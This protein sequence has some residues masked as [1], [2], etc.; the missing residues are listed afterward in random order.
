MLL[1]EVYSILSRSFW[2][3]GAGIAQVPRL[4]LC[5][6]CPGDSHYCSVMPPKCLSHLIN[7]QLD[8]TTRVS[9]VLRAQVV[10]LEFLRECPTRVRGE[11]HCPLKSQWEAAAGSRVLQRPLKSQAGSAACQEGK[12]PGKLFLKGGKSRV[13]I[14]ALLLEPGL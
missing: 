8:S 6:F 3:A 9:L 2:K 14:S 7:W 11:A 10:I 5:L 4:A 13:L 1:R 12:R